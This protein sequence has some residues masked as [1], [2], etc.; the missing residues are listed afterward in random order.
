MWPNPHFPADMVTF[1]EE[2]LNGNFIFVQWNTNGQKYIKPEN[3]LL[4]YLKILSSRSKSEQILKLLTFG[5]SLL[6]C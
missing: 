4:K 1:T 3:L 5:T 6:I 2:I